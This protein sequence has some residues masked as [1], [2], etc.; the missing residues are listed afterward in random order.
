MAIENGNLHACYCM[1]CRNIF[2]HS[3]N[4]EP[5]DPDPVDICP[6]CTENLTSRIEMRHLKALLQELQKYYTI[7]R[8][9]MTLIAQIE[10]LILTP[11]DKLKESWLGNWTYLSMKLQEN[12]DL[13]LRDYLVL[14]KL[15]IHGRKRK[16]IINRLKTKFNS[17]RANEEWRL[18]VKGYNL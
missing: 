9:L 13:S 18:L 7:E 15:E 11:E 10:S 12:K 14:I 2:T 8:G 16:D 5:D 17:F 3:C 1:V 4:L 6:S